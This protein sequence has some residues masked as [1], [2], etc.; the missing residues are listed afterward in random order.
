MDDVGLRFTL[1]SGIIKTLI[2]I[3][4]VGFLPGLYFPYIKFTNAKKHPLIAIPLSFI[5]GVVCG[6]V[7]VF[8]ASNFYHPLQPL[9]PQ[10]SNWAL[11]ANILFLIGV[12]EIIVISVHLFNFRKRKQKKK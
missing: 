2:A 4:L 3:F 5:I 6:G 9:E 8:S 1:G 10:N 11:L 12:L 7:C